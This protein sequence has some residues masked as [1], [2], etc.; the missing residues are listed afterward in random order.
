M[1]LVFAIHVTP[2]AKLLEAEDSH[3]TTFPICP[4][5]VNVVEFVPVQTVA[6]PAIVPPTDTELTV[7]E[8]VALVAAEQ[9]PFVT[10][11]R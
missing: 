5:S 4:L 6:L 7:I 10:I 8:A 1:V 3:L 11:A 2:D 9:E